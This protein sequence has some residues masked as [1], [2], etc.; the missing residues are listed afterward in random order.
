MF[1]N[2]LIFEVLLHDGLY[3]HVYPQSGHQDHV[4]SAICAPHA[5]HFGL[6]VCQKIPPSSSPP[7]QSF[8]VHPPRCLQKKTYFSPYADDVL[9]VKGFDLQEFE[10]ETEDHA[11]VS[12]WRIVP[13]HTTKTPEK[14][15]KIPV[16]IQHGLLDCAMSWFLHSKM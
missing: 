11:F 14:N 6:Q 13:N 3:P 7:F 15:L 10:F 16:I 1:D 4:R 12:F 5:T 2:I 9:K 8:Q